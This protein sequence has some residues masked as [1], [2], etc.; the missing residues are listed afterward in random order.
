MDSKNIARS[1][2]RNIVYRAEKIQSVLKSTLND[3]I[4]LVSDHLQELTKE[5]QRLVLEAQSLE[6]SMQ[7]SDL[8]SKAAEDLTEDEKAAL[9]EGFSQHLT[10]AARTVN[11]WPH[12]KKGCLGQPR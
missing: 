3:P 10:N 5:A 9:N 2:I 7:T 8:R 6:E 12:W 1:Q 4:T 11:D